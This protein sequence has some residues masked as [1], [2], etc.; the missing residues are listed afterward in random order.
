MWDL[1]MG[2]MRPIMKPADIRKAVTEWASKGF[3]CHVLPDG[4]IRVEPAG[5]EQPKD[6][7]DLV[8]MRRT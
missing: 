3:R 5:A 2:E 4:S 6:Q 7:F 8:D 1:I